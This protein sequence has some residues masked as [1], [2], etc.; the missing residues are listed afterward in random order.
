MSDETY[1]TLNKGHKNVGSHAPDPIAAALE[2]L[3]DAAVTAEQDSWASPDQDLGI[4][5][6][7]GYVATKLLPFVRAAVA[8]RDLVTFVHGDSCRECQRVIA[9]FDREARALG[10]G[11]RTT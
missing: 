5:A 2:R 4:R 10:L 7:A 8:L 6:G 1:S 3:A 9:A 11:E